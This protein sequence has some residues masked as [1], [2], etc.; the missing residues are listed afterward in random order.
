[1]PLLLG[2]FSGGINQMEVIKA[3]INKMT[4]PSILAKY[5]EILD[6]VADCVMTDIPSNVIYDL[7]KYKLSNDVTWT[8]DSYTVT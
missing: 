1:M 8:I 6:E 3:V 4:S 5:G 2:M 7:V